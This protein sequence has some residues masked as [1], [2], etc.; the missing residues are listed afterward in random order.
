MDTSMLEKL[1]DQYPASVM[2]VRF[3]PMS[4]ASASGS[5]ITDVDG[6][7]YLDFTAAWAVANLGYDNERVKR[8][9]AE[10]FS[11]T[12]F[13]TLTAMMNEQSVRLAERLIDLVPGDFDKKVWY[14]MHGSDANDCIAKLVP[15]AT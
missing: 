14:G 6:K 2:K 13:G 3:F 9:V 7:T 5:R 4:I 11:K 15:L 1:D 12:T 8:A 10:E